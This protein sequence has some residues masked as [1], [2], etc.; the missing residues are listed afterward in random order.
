MAQQT[1]TRQPAKP[2]IAAD[3]IAFTVIG[4]GL[5]GAEWLKRLEKGGQ[6]V[7]DRARDILTRPD[8]DANHRLETGKEYKIVL[9]N[10]NEIPKDSERKT[11]KLKEFARRELGRTENLRAFERRELG[12][13]AVA[14]LK[15]EHALLIREKFTNAELEKMGLWYIVILHKP[16]VDSSGDARVLD[17]DRAD[18]KPWVS[19]FC[20][21]PDHRW[22]NRGAFAF[23]S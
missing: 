18:D 3:R 6:T 14:E 9:V 7:S 5:S 22:S 11:D 4:T 13:K 10:G 20:D 1:P 16:I 2:A 23:L 12:E 15:G 19:A 17:T 8:Y 21:D